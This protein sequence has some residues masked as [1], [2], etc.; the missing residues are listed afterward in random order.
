MGGFPEEKP[1]EALCEVSLLSFGKYNG[2][3][4]K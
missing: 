1:L 2:T 4:L 3:G